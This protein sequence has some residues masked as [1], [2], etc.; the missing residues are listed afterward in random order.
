MPLSPDSAADESP[1]YPLRYPSITED[2]S[3]M[4]YSIAFSLVFSLLSASLYYHSYIERSQL[5]L[6][7]NFK[8]IAT[9]LDRLRCSLKDFCSVIFI[10]R[11][12][13]GAS[14]K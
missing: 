9:H 5:R 1:Y 13:Y 11:H 12:N 3:L 2:G 7:E 4:S 6:F 8:R 14:G 10:E